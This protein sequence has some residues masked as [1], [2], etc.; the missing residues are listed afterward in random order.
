MAADSSCSNRLPCLKFVGDKLSVSTLISLVTLTFD[1]LTSNL[2][3]VIARGV[4]NLPSNLGVS[5]T[6]RSRLMDRQLS[7]VPRGIATLTFNLGG[8]GACR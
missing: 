6:S 1:L 4:V 8:H 2:V 3:R 5:G 7:E